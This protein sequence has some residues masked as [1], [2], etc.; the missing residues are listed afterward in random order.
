[1]VEIFKILLFYYLDVLFNSVVGVV[2][3]AVLNVVYVYF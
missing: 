1:M 3:L 2:C